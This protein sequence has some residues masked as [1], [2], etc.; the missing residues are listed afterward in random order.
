MNRRIHDKIEED[1]ESLGSLQTRIE[2]TT[3]WVPRFVSK[4]TSGSGDLLDESISHRKKAYET[5]YPTRYT[6][7]SKG[8]VS[9]ENLRDTSQ[10]LL[11][12][13]REA[14]TAKELWWQ[15][16]QKSV[17]SAEKWESWL[18]AISGGILGGFLV[19]SV[20]GFFPD[21][22]DLRNYFIDRLPHLSDRWTK[23]LKGPTFLL[24]TG[25]AILFMG[26]IHGVVVPHEPEDKLPEKEELRKLALEAREGIKTKDPKI[27][28]K[29]GQFT[30]RTEQVVETELLT[31]AEKEVEL[32]QWNSL[33]ETYRGLAASKKSDD[34]KGQVQA[35]MHYNFE[36]YFQHYVRSNALI[37]QV[38]KG[39]GG[40]CETSTKMTIAA[41]YESGIELPEGYILGVQKFRDHMQPVIYSTK[42]GWMWDLMENQWTQEIRAPIFQVTILYHAFLKSQKVDPKVSEKELLIAPSNSVDD[43]P[44]TAR[45]DA[46][47]SNLLFPQGSGYY[48]SGPAPEEA[49]LKNPYATSEGDRFQTPVEDKQGVRQKKRENQ[50]KLK[51]VYALGDLRTDWKQYYESLFSSEENI[52]PCLIERDGELVIFN[53][54]LQRNHYRSLLSDEARAN[55]LMNLAFSSLSGLLDRSYLNDSINLLEDSKQI[56]NFDRERFTSVKK[57]MMKIFNTIALT[58]KYLPPSH[59]TQLIQRLKEAYPEFERLMN[60]KIKFERDVLENPAST[61]KFLGELNHDQRFN[62]LELMAAIGGTYLS[63]RWGGFY[64]TFPLSEA[65]KAMEREAQNGELPPEVMVDLILY[66]GGGEETTIT[67]Q[68]DQQIQ[69]TFLRLNGDQSYNNF[70]LESFRRWPIQIKTDGGV[71]SAT[72]LGFLLQSGTDFEEFY[73]IPKNT[74]RE[75]KEI[76]TSILG[77]PAREGEIVHDPALLRKMRQ[78]YLIQ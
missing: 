48:N 77:K 6:L 5:L 26:F 46:T 40:N 24:F 17:A 20:F 57:L 68:W 42:Y 43:T 41:F 13:S 19:G 63:P 7:E 38:L 32:S 18:Q 47:N 21:R 50:D 3:H 27:L 66:Y 78:Q 61:L 67:R 59:H 22:G 36:N 12:A 65:E 2:N 25:A 30:I 53:N 33:G 45:H 9:P 56:R 39:F 73:V 29:I 16:N 62:L 11:S 70:F 34:W 52:L 74:R 54:V 71:P 37:R 14:Q 55:F 23:N 31:K 60:L 51:G 35:I 64:S 4:W 44:R 76:L 28:R 15:Y 72:K 75:F 8:V 49:Y 58:K 10:R 69:G 1:L